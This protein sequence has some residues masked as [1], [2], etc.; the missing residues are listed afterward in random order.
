[1]RQRQEVQALPRGGV[2]RRSTASAALI[3]CLVA[4]S[5]ATEEPVTTTSIVQ[6]TT[7]TTT[8]ATT[9]TVA[10]VT[11]TTLPAT[12]TTLP[13]LPP[14]KDDLEHGGQAW[15]VYLAVS[16]DFTD[17]DLLEAATVADTY[18]YFAGVTD[19]NCDQG[20]AA[21]VGIAPGGSEAVVGIYFDSEAD[22]EAFIL[23]WEAR[24]L[25]TIGSGLVQT[26]CLD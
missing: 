15:A 25:E 5:A 6:S 12:T 13:E 2:T 1:M 23:A 11:T 21:A 8:P 20:A 14:A 26:F 22:A 10:Q 16:E 7:T 24:G 3:F 18:G 17:P 19:I 4:C 9:S